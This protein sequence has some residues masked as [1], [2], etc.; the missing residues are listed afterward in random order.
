MLFSTFSS[1]VALAIFCCCCVAL[2]LLLFFFFSSSLP[3]A[4]FPFVVFL[5]LKL[6]SFSSF[7]LLLFPFS[8]SLAFSVPLWYSFPFPQDL[9]FLQSL[10]LSLFSFFFNAL[11]LS[12]FLPIAIFLFRLSVSIFPSLFASFCVSQA[13]F[14]YQSLFII[15][16]LFLKPPF[17]PNFSHTLLF[18]F[19]LSALIFRLF[20][21]FSSSIIFQ[22]SISLSLFPP[23]SSLFCFLKLSVPS[24]S[25]SLSPSLWIS[26]SQPLCLFPPSSFSL[27]LP[28]ASP[29]HRNRTVTHMRDHH[30]SQ[31]RHTQVTTPPTEHFSSDTLSPGPLATA[32]SQRCPG[33]P[34]IDR[35]KSSRISPLLDR[36][37]HS[38]EEFIFFPLLDTYGYM[39]VYFRLEDWWWEG[40]MCILGEI[41]SQSR[42]GFVDCFGGWRRGLMNVWDG[43]R[44][45]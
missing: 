38:P 34:P 7:S 2:L 27:P 26:L 20:P 41:G 17:S 12:V 33:F 40:V 25:A 16:Y 9:F 18:S 4:V 13:L 39:D 32:V 31:P 1:C 15:V 30:T 10:F 37:E 45:Y 35:W 21:L 29:Y 3:L 11:P 43:I 22:S 5:F 36:V 24:N 23:F 28:P 44:K 19:P 8:Q 42:W 6:S 14:L